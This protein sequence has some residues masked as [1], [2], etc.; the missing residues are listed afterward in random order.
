MIHVF[1][2]DSIGVGEDGP[3]HEPVALILSR[4]AMPTLDRGRFA[5][6]AG[7]RRGA[8]VLADPPEGDRGRSSSPPAARS[9]SR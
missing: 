4:Q 6:A 2:H 5:P 1:A 3:T 9:A 7:L 8:W